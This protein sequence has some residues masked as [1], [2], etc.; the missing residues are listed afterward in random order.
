[1]FDHD[2]V[3]QGAILACRSTRAKMPNGEII[4]PLRKF[5]S[6]GSAL[7]FPVE[8]MY[9][10]TICVVALLK[11]NGLP[12]SL[13]NIYHVSRDVYV[14]GDD[15]LVPT[16][17]ATVVLDYL[18]RYNCKVNNAKTFY[19]GKFRESCGVDAYNGRVVTPLYLRRCLPVN[20]QQAA[21]LISCISVA[22]AFYKKGYWRTCSH[23]FKR[24]EKI[25]GPLPYVSET[26]PVLGRF[27]YLGYQTIHRWND[28]LQTSEVEGWVPRPKYRT[29]V[30]DGYGALEKSF[31]RLEDL[32][33]LPVSRDTRHLE[34]SALHHAV[35]LK[36][37]RVAT[38]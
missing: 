32:N 1:M 16:K 14:Y 23:L 8:A 13:D 6:M 17:H 22:N 38:P 30:L 11:E 2:P 34:H 7:C 3:L 35:A 15:I 25:L 24:C 9:F 28:K 21:E 19:S 27:S 37:G 4:S 20:K 33:N 10:Y 31:Q 5:A 12:V 36:R 29:D 26:S 18:Q